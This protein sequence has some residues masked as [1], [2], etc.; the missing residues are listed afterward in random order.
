MKKGA[1]GHRGL[2]RGGPHHVQASGDSLEKELARPILV[3]SRCLGFEACRWN[4]EVVKDPFVELLVP[5][6]NAVTVC[7]EV[8]MGLGIPRDPVHLEDWGDGI[9]LIQF[10]KGV[11]HTDR[12]RAFSRE[13][14]NG[15][16][17]VDGFILKAR[18]P[19]CGSRDVK[20]FP[21]GSGDRG[22][23]GKGIGIFAAE[24]MER[25]PGLP[26]ETEG[27]LRNHRIREHFLTRIFL[28]ARF[29]GAQATGTRGSLVDFHT[30]HKLML[31]AYHQ[32]ELRSMG[33]LVAQAADLPTKDLFTLYRAHLLKAVSRLPRRNSH[34]NVLMHAMG[35]FSRYL[36]SREK[37]HFLTLLERFREGK[38][39]LSAPLAVINSW[40]VRFGQEYLQSQHYFHP[41]P[42]GLMV[43][44]DSGKGRDF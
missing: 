1:A 27:R 19:S 42:E 16:K 4:A 17:E 31:M 20:V 8:D 41:Y 10:K 21:P 7:P 44:D 12:M 37:S 14:L 5:Y 6:V 38:L 22:A 40:I 25:F 39:P 24:V 15:L 2:S 26:V 18:S 33:R 36:T 13:F 11:D 3:I 35:Y 23:I 34:A 32:Q 43:L 28:L 29:R 30:R 9:R